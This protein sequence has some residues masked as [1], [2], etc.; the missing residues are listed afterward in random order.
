MVKSDIPPSLCMTC[1]H[2]VEQTEQ[3]SCSVHTYFHMGHLHTY[4]RNNEYFSKHM[5]CCI[6]GQDV[7]DKHIIKCSHH[8]D[9]R[10]K[11]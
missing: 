3:V 7:Y 6:T 2:R 10:I 8:K 4:K 11:L 1:S 9:S 5:T